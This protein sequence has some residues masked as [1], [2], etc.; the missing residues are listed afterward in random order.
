MRNFKGELTTL[1][2][3]REILDAVKN[4]SLENMEL[5]RALKRTLP[6]SCFVNGNRAFFDI[7]K[8]EKY[9][10]SEDEIYFASIAAKKWAK[11]VKEFT[12]AKSRREALRAVAIRDIGIALPEKI[13]KEIADI[14]GVTIEKCSNWKELEQTRALVFDIIEGITLSQADALLGETKG[15]K[16]TSK[17]FASVI[18]KNMVEN[19]NKLIK[20][21]K[22]KKLLEK[23]VFIIDDPR[24]SDVCEQMI[25]YDKS[26]KGKVYYG[27][28]KLP[29]IILCYSE[30]GERKVLLHEHYGWH[31]SLAYDNNQTKKLKL[32]VDNG[33]AIFMSFDVRSENKLKE[34]SLDETDLFM[35]V[36]NWNKEKAFYSRDIA[37]ATFKALYAMMDYAGLKKYIPAIE[38]IYFR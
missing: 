7:S 4:P 14:M 20:S 26:S 16:I 8:I 2:E 1:K 9:L 13:A 21:S 19:I 38:D 25:R 23:D 34:C 33:M 10:I 24:L 15:K 30:N 5:R 28:N 32:A 18:E 37:T 22:S 29:D 6:K 31:G 17:Y 36:Y 3:R 35:K 11:E 27:T 12:D